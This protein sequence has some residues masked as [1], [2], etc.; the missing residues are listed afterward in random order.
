MFKG[1]NNVALGYDEGSILIKV[2]QLCDLIIYFCMYL[3]IFVATLSI[4]VLTERNLIFSLDGKSQPCP[5]IPMVKLFLPSTV[6]FNRL[7]LKMWLVSVNMCILT[8]T[9][10]YSTVKCRQSG[11]VHIQ[12]SIIIQLC[13]QRESCSVS[14]ERSLYE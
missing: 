4:L 5:W 9:S 8:C 12:T 3:S 10:M 2:F 14:T 11:A 6:K 13:I 7:T 1:S